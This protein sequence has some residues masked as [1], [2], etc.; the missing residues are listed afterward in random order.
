MR[1]GW[2]LEVA[3]GYGRCIA[4][5]GKGERVLREEKLTRV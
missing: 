3:W 5:R 4:E 2:G 1:Q